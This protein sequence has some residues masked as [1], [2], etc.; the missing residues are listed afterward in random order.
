MKKTNNNNKLT[1][2]QK[3]YIIDTIKNNELRVMQCIIKK[4]GSE[5][6]ESE[7]IN[8]IQHLYL[9]DGVYILNL[10]DATILKKDGTEP[11]DMILKKRKLSFEFINKKFIPIFSMSGHIDYWDIP[12]PTYD[13]I[14]YIFN[15]NKPDNIVTKWENKKY[16]KAI[17]RGSPTGCGY[18]TE[19]NM[20]LK[21]ATIKSPDLDA[22][23]VSSNTN[24]INSKSI[25]FDPIYGLGMLNTNIKPTNFVSMSEQSNYKY[26]VYIDGNVHAYRLLTNLIFGSVILRVLSPYTSWVDTILQP[27]KHYI[28]INHDLS[29]LLDI[30]Q[31]CKSNDQQCKK[32]AHQGYTIAKQIL[33]LKYTQSAFQDLLWNTSKLTKNKTMKRCPN[34]YHKDPDNSDVCLPKKQIN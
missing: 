5:N 1:N 28:P 6:Q 26:I 4:Y 12:I 34:G 8:L 13:D 14:F 20:R 30:I 27:F 29:N 21:I 24:T 18:T 15:I 10:T 22:G 3:K 7:Y 17:F 16:N 2:F 33:T 32:I 31:W 11:W 19:T 9:P 23:I 25:R